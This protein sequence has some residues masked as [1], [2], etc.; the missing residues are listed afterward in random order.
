MA[1]VSNAEVCV[2]ILSLDDN[3]SSVKVRDQLV[4]WNKRISTRLYTSQVD[5]YQSLFEK[6]SDKISKMLDPPPSSPP[7]TSPSVQGSLLSDHPLSSG[8]GS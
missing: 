7:P 2:Q 4:E 5:V 1:V 6:I 8:K 3:Q